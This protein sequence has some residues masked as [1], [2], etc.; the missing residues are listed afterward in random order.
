MRKP[1][2]ILAGVAVALAG[3]TAVAAAERAH[4][5]VLTVMLPDGS[6]EHVRYSGDV[7]PRIVV[8]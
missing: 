5:H 6:V 1:S 2:L 3:A 4:D 7:A 8:R